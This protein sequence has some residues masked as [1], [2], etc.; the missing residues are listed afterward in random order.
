MLI[1]L[2]LAL[3]FVAASIA[4]QSG[5]GQTTRYWYALE[6]SSTSTNKVVFN[7]YSGTAVKL[8]VHG[9]EKLPPP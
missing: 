4:A 8:L 9:A 3:P 5:T 1:R 7:L 2:A 6:V